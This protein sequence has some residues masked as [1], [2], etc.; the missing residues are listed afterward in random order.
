MVLLFHC[1]SSHAC[2]SLA[3]LVETKTKKKN[4]FKIIIGFSFTSPLFLAT[5]VAIS[6]VYK[7]PKTIKCTQKPKIERSLQGIDQAS[8][9]VPFPTSYLQ[10]AL[11]RARNSRV[12][13]TRAINLRP[14]KIRNLGANSKL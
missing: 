8:E 10:L 5:K 14:L 2:Q 13:K 9:R 4:S 3:L 6:F 11:A 7:S 1:E 12:K